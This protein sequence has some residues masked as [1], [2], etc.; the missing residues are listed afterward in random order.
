MAETEEGEFYGSEVDEI[1]LQQFQ[2]NPN[3]PNTQSKVNTSKKSILNLDES[4]KLSTKGSI[5]N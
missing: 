5:G 4:R 3:S 1:D 2:Y